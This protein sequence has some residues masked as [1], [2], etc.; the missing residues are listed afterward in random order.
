[1]TQEQGGLIDEIFNFVGFVGASGSGLGSVESFDT[2]LVQ[3]GRVKFF[4]CIIDQLM[5]VE[6]G[7]LLYRLASVR[8]CVTPRVIPKLDTPVSCRCRVFGDQPKGCDK[9]GGIEQSICYVADPIR[10]KCAA[11]STV[12]PG[13]AW[14]YCGDSHSEMST[15]LGVYDE[16]N[17]IEPYGQDGYCNVINPKLDRKF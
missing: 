12:Y 7:E 3:E 1:M 4:G 6:A 17:S 5:Q 11:Q 16:F 13:L 15:W 9:H 8:R 10:C 2:D 14:R